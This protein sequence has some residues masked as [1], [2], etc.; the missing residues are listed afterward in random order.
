MPWIPNVPYFPDL[1]DLLL[2]T[3]PL[4]S[5]VVRSDTDTAPH[6]KGKTPPDALTKKHASTRKT[7]D[8]ANDTALGIQQQSRK[9]KIEHDK[10]ANTTPKLKPFQRAKSEAQDL[11]DWHDLPEK[12][13]DLRRNVSTSCSSEINDLSAALESR[14]SLSKRR[15]ASKARLRALKL[16][17]WA[18]D[19]KGGAVHYREP[20]YRDDRRYNS[21]TTSGNASTHFG[22]GLGDGNLVQCFVDGC[23]TT[24]PFISFLL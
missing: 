22:H 17:Y 12:K 13:A 24:K 16:Q 5:P 21:F 11:D 23:D 15:S 2:T 8:L 6:D 1:I 18:D 10:I 9:S 20:E 4:S 7:H 3:D 14:L 19:F